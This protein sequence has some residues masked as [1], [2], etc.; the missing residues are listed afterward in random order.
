[1]KRVDIKKTRAPD[2]L[3]ESQPP[4]SLTRTQTDPHNH[5]IVGVFLRP[6]HLALVNVAPELSQVLKRLGLLGVH[7]PYPCEGFILDWKKVRFDCY[8][9]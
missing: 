6:A 9:H 3:L 2:E 1:M 7:P 8:I 5:Q 4:N